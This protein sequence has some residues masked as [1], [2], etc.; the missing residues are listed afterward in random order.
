MLASEVW[1]Q[2]KLGE[3]F[4]VKHGFAFKGEHFSDDPG[5]VILTPGNFDPSGG[6]AFR[7]EKD[8]SYTGEFPSEF[9]LER[10]DMLI[11]MTDL[12]QEARILRCPGLRASRP[13]LPT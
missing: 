12:T 5:E 3:L 6:L 2:A 11:V 7:P 13:N 8:R 10:G 9:R 4:K 1:P